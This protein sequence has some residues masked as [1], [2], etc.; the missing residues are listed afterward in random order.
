[1]GRILKG[2]KRRVNTGFSVSPDT[3]SSFDKA[4]GNVPRSTVLEALMIAYV[5]NPAIAELPGP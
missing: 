3:L 2:G 4:I 5:K 1:L